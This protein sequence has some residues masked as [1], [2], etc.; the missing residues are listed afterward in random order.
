MSNSINFAINNTKRDKFSK[1][2]IHSN[3]CHI[4]YKQIVRAL[5]SHIIYYQ[6]PKSIDIS[7]LNIGLNKLEEACRLMPR[8]DQKR[9]KGKEKSKKKK[10]KALIKADFGP[11]PLQTYTIVRLLC[12][13]SLNIGRISYVVVR[14]KEKKL[15]TVCNTTDP[16]FFLSLHSNPLIDA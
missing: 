2:Y 16:F 7:P 5:T 15:F 10:K 6:N 12:V 1:K 9:K 14:E 3:N 11:L 8:I 4:I 13:H